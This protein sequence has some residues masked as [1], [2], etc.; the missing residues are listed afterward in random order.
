MKLHPYPTK[1][2]IRIP[3]SVAALVNRRTDSSML[4][5][6]GTNGQLLNDDQLSTLFLFGD[7]CKVDRHL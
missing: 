5:Q 4:D 1:Y 6:S 3:H 7:F 2:M